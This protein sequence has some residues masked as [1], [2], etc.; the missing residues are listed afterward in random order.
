MKDVIKAVLDVDEYA[1]VREWLGEH[2]Y[3]GA[4][5]ELEVNCGKSQD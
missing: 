3:D 2:Y 1:D 4:V 5:L